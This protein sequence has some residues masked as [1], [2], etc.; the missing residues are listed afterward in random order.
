MLHEQ[1]IPSRRYTALDP[2]NAHSQA[3]DLTLMC[4]MQFNSDERECQQRRQDADRQL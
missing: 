4:V 3:A 1:Q 2:M